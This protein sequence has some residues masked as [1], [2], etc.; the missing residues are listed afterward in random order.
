MATARDYL[1]SILGRL[2]RLQNEADQD[3]EKVRE[4]LK[5]VDNVFDNVEDLMYGEGQE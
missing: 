3:L 2:A 1:S 5:E 4:E